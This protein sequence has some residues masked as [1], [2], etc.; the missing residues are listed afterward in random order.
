MGFNTR[1]AETLLQQLL[2]QGATASYM[3]AMI[4]RQMRLIVRVRELKRQGLKEPE[5]RQ[6]LGVPSEYVVRKTLEQANRYSMPRIKEVYEQLLNID[7]AIKTGKYPEE[8]ALNILIAELCQRT[9][10][11]AI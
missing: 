5:M 6:R 3:L 10:A 7:I 8:L 9:P 11:T 1:E 4:Y 2:Q